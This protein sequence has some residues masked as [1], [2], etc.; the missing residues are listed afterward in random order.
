MQTKPYL[1]LRSK[2]VGRRRARASRTGVLAQVRDGRPGLRQL[3]RQERATRSSSATR[4]PHRRPPTPAWGTPKRLLYIRQPYANHNGGCLQFG[5]DG[6]LYIGMGDGGSGGDPGNRA[7]NRTLLLGKMLRINPSKS[8]ATKPYLIPPTNPS[9]LTKTA[10]LRGRAPRSGRSACETRGG[11]RSTRAP[12]R[13][14]SR[15]WARTRSRRSTTS[16]G[17]RPRRAWT[18]A[19]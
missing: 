7:Q 17:R 2:I 5:P 19:G 3:H 11:S 18:T 10:S 6:Y 13:C 9:K 4:R 16:R 12:G 14:G 15:T 8:G 1:D